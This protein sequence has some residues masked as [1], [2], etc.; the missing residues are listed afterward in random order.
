MIRTPFVAHPPSILVIHARSSVVTQ[1]Q[2]AGATLGLPVRIAEDT[3]SAAEIARASRP[4]V[5][6]CDA[7]AGIADASLSSHIAAQLDAE[8]V[9]VE[10]GED[11]AALVVTLREASARA[12][13][14]RA[15]SQPPG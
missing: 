12:E 11:P 5:L 3:A 13:R 14:R 6:V 8:V 10:G 4:L 7:A 1:C 9:Q 2:A 15:A